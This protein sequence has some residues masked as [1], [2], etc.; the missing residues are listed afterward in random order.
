[1]TRLRS[2]SIKLPC[3]IEIFQT[4]LVIL[5]QSLFATSTNDFYDENIYSF[6]ISSHIIRIRKNKFE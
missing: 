4:N 6:H 1:M 2:S 3:A 5:D